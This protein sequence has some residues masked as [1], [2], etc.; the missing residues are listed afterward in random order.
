MT[1][2]EQS[3]FA[4]IP[5]TILPL[6]LNDRDITPTYNRIA[7]ITPEALAGFVELRENG[8][9]DDLLYMLYHTKYDGRSLEDWHQSQGHFE[10]DPAALAYRAG[11]LYGVQMYER[12]YAETHDDKLAPHTLVETDAYEK[13]VEVLAASYAPAPPE[14][15]AS[16]WR[17]ECDRERAYLGAGQDLAHLSSLL[18]PRLRDYL[19]DAQAPEA[20]YTGLLDASI[21]LRTYIYLKDTGFEPQRYFAL[22]DDLPVKGYA[23]PGVDMAGVAVLYNHSYPDQKFDIVVPHG[24]LK[25]IE[26]AWA[27]TPYQWRIV[28]D[29][30]ALGRGM[31]LAEVPAYHVFV[32]TSLDLVAAH[33]ERKQTVLLALPAQTERSGYEMAADIVGGLKANPDTFPPEVPIATFTE[34][35]STQLGECLSV[36]PDSPNARVANETAFVLGLLNTYFMPRQTEAETAA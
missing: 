5:P 8:P 26:D 11:Q 33:I 35:V 18:A 32:A 10:G 25:S 30:E 9:S 7:S 2:A 13:A 27:H 22:S 15:L 6:E 19:Q 28:V 29:G 4:E 16:R 12:K 34:Q 17:Q 3:A 36:V 20:F 31:S 23:L 14:S 21:F 24:R 1:T